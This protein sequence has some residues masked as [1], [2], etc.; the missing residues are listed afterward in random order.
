MIIS[1]YPG[2]DH[3]SAALKFCQTYRLY[4]IILSSVN[5]FWL[6]FVKN[7]RISRYFLHYKSSLNGLFCNF[8]RFE[9]KDAIINPFRWLMIQMNTFPWS[10]RQ[11]LT[12]NPLSIPLAGRNLRRNRSTQKNG[13]ESLALL[14][15]VL[16]ILTDDHNAALALDDLALFADGLYG[17]S[18]FHDVA[19]YLYPIGQLFERQVMRPRVRS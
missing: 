2:S 14:L 4:H 10:A 17:R 18:H 11:I 19:S 6:H 8:S 1:I 7:Q 15:L 16:R 5:K 12:E 3:S 9:G 13:N